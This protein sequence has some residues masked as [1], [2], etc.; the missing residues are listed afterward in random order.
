MRKM[1]QGDPILGWLFKLRDALEHAAWR[2]DDA[3]GA[4]MGQ[5]PL[6]GHLREMTSELN[7]AHRRIR[8]LKRKGVVM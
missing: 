1:S 7:T 3:I 5:W 8:D 4:Q 2:V 6:D